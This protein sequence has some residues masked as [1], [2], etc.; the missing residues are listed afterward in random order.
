MS[1]RFLSSMLLGLLFLMGASSMF[2]SCKDYDD[3]IK[4]LQEQID[5]NAKAIDQIN[6]LV[7]DGSVISEVRK[8]ADGIEVVMANGTTYKI[9]NGTNA[10]VWTIGDDGY[11]YK[12]GVKTD[13]YAIGKDGANGINGTNGTNGTNG[14]DG[15]DGKDGIYYVP[16]TE[17]GCWDIYNGDGTLKE[18]T[19]ISWKAATN[20]IT[21]VM[22]GSDLMLYN[23]R[24][25]NG[26]ADFTVALSNILRGF[27]FQPEIYVDGV[28]GFRVASFGYEAYKMTRMDNGKNGDGEDG[29]QLGM[30]EFIGKDAMTYKSRKTVIKYHVNP[31]NAN[32][33]DLQNLKF[34]VK[35]NDEFLV[36][37]HSAPA[38]ND[39]D[40]EAKFAGF[41]N[42]I[43]SVEVV[44]RG[45]PATDEFISVVAL[46]T[47]LASGEDVTSDYATVIKSDLNDIHIADPNRC[48][49]KPNE[50]YHYRTVLHSKDNSCDKIGIKD[51][52]VTHKLDMDGETCDLQLKWD[53]ELN[54]WNFITAH[55]IGETCK[56]VN[57]ADLGFTWK[58]ELMKKFEFGDN[59]TDQA[60]YVDF[61]ET[62]GILKVKEKYGESAID[63]T[64][65]IRVRI[66]DGNKT[67]KLAYIKVKIVRTPE[68]IQNFAAIFTGEDFTFKCNQDEG[69][70]VYDYKDFSISVLR[71]YHYSW[72]EF[73]SI[74][75]VENGEDV[76]G[77]GTFTDNLTGQQVMIDNRTK[78]HYELGVVTQS[79]DLVE[80]PSEEGTVV[81]YWTISND[82][83]WA[84]AGET[85][86]NRYRFWAP[87]HVHY[88][89][90]ILCA[91]IKD[92]KK[93]YA[94][95]TPSYI[96]NYWFENYAY[97]KLNVNVPNP[98]YDTIPAH[99]IFEN[100]LNSAFVTENGFVKISDPDPNFVL[101]GMR[102]Y[103]CNDMTAKEYSIRNNGSELWY[104]NN[105]ICWLENAPTYNQFR[106]NKNN[107]KAKEL[108]NRGDMEVYIGA[109]ALVCGKYPVSITFRDADHF[110]AK[111]IRPVT[112]EGNNVHPDY[113][114]DGVDYGEAHSYVDADQFLNRLV[115]WRDRDFVNHPTFWKYY[116]PF[117]CNFHTSTAV[118]NLKVDGNSAWKPIPST[119]VF[120][121]E[122]TP[123]LGHENRFGWLTYKNNGTNVDDDFY[124]KV[125]L[126]IN[127]GWGTYTIKDVQILVQ[128]TSNT[129]N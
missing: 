68:P 31:T 18:S 10:T 100:N 69:K 20:E 84:H 57:L 9:T 71:P 95:K 91:K 64:P 82:D 86:Y 50:N 30:E 21:A 34:V 123:W 129:P 14:K 5:K 89:D 70:F 120:K 47:E 39:F 127:Y 119:I 56:D 15:K 33:E 7:T 99:C 36:T 1:K 81:L 93:S 102:Y 52:A 59:G 58:L 125:D 43:L 41:E 78:N 128:A 51:Y 49:N 42:G 17:T 109:S 74:Y 25:T 26:Y 8:V 72:D 115:D 79:N 4:N 75:P 107:D 23:V 80:D 61:D 40:A 105:L 76:T 29:T 53:G 66:M 2:T 98:E 88:F 112:L 101:S 19:N 94:V 83:L 44:V 114:I 108:L 32:V 27:V 16:N 54:I 62:T 60:E 38:S 12:D 111:V 48:T 90:I 97:T 92:I 35:A 37:R 77:T 113:F 110:V 65:V 73:Q 116:G 24:T 106:Y 55:E 63:R 46:Q 104:G 117:T 87:D 85:V 126:D 122:P 118:C 103:F 22:N 3:D 13:Y 6:S 96:D 124:I 67:V 45:V 28:P 11:W 121:Y